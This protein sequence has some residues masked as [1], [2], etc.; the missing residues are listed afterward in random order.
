MTNSGPIEK[1]GVLHF[2]RNPLDALFPQKG[3]DLDRFR[4]SHTQALHQIAER[5]TGVDDVFDDQTG[6]LPAIS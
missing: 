2:D 1:P 3:G 6:V 4:L 5:Q